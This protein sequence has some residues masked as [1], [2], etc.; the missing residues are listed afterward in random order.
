[1]TAQRTEQIIDGWYKVFVNDKDHITPFAEVSGC[2]KYSRTAAWADH[3]LHFLQRLKVDGIIQVRKQYV[4][5]TWFKMAKLRQEAPPGG[6]E[7][8]NLRVSLPLLKASQ[9]LDNAEYTAILLSELDMG[10]ALPFRIHEALGIPDPALAAA[11]A[12]LPTSPKGNKR[13]LD[14]DGSSSD[15][16][17]KAEGELADVGKAAKKARLD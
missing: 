17:R 2:D 3:Q 7:N 5:R 10:R 14:D 13:K 12:A 16:G 15:D 4:R 1:M 6:Y 8:Y 9:L 11:Q